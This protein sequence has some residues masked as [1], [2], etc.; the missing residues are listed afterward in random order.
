MIFGNLDRCANGL[1]A[2]AAMPVRTSVDKQAG[3]IIGCGA[4]V[5]RCGDDKL[6]GFINKGGT[7]GGCG[8]RERSFENRNSL[9][10]FEQSFFSPGWGTAYT[11][12]NFPRGSFIPA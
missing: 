1:A 4:P 5:T 2:E 9:L 11:V 12:L 3:F 8:W 6:G 7:K 10:R